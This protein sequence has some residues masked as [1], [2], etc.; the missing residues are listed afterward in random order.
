[1][2]D[3]SNSE[4]KPSSSVTRELESLR[5]TNRRL[6]LELA[7]KEEINEQLQ[8]LLRHSQETTQHL[9]IGL[10]SVNSSKQFKSTSI[11][12]GACGSYSLH[13]EVYLSLHAHGRAHAGTV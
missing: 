12:D 2:D 8:R 4:L 13:R 1:M 11:L 7:D 10:C 9:R 3:S 6:L 5:E